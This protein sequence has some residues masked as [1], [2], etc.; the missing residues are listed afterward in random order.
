[1]VYKTNGVSHKMKIDIKLLEPLKG[2]IEDG[3]DVL[4]NLNSN[5]RIAITKEQ[6]GQLLKKEPDY[7]LTPRGRVVTFGE[8]AD[9]FFLLGLGHE[10]ATKILNNNGLRDTS[11]ES[12]EG[13]P[14]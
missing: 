14:F 1:M 10:A 6:N 8:R 13:R 4:R 11:A 3:N 12:V 7:Y 2:K 9:G 5:F